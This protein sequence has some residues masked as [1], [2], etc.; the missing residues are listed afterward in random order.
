MIWLVLR[1]VLL[2]LMLLGL[3]AL[4]GLLLDS[5]GRVTLSIMGRE[6]P[7]L[8]LVE[9]LLAIA[10]MS[11]ALYLLYRLA[12][13]A[14]AV[15]RFIL[16]DETAL[17]RHWA[18]ARE[19]RG[20]DALSRGMIALAEGDARAADNHARKATRL[21]GKRELTQLLS[22][23]V[24]EAL[25]DDKRA[26]ESYRALA[27]SPETAMVGVKGLMTQAVRQGEIER[28]M[29]LA[30]HAFTLRP[31][32]PGVQQTLFDLQTRSGAWEGAKATLS[33]MEKT[34][35][36][37]ADVAARR[38]AVL[39]L[40]I[41]RVSWAE[42]DR[43]LALRHADAAVKAAQD[44]A[45]AAAFAAELHAAAGDAG[46][47]A[48]LLKSA[49]R[50]NPQPELAQAFAALEPGETPAERRR[51]FREL[52]SGKPDDPESKLLAAE[53]AIADHDA[54]AARKAL[55]DLADSD[56][57]HR[58]LAIM[59][60]VEKAEGA[61]ETVVRGYLARAVTA[62][63]GAHWRCERCAAAPGGWSAVC[64]ACGGFD[65]LAWRSDAGA[66]AGDAATMTPLLV[67]IGGGEGSNEA[68][69][70]DE[71]AAE[72]AGRQAAEARA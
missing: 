1:V 26:R 36:L 62:P 44:F 34:R 58:S 2:L 50:A 39:D 46:R 5:D 32:D 51:R 49:W 21:L 12:A 60:A 69:A 6:Y 25:G 23:Q 61:A 15:L 4:G 18:R 8:T 67:G 53:L 31:Q 47:A 68:D 7:S 55:G 57:T 30:A 40:E 20:L 54:H 59:A 22:A 29:K 48:R 19:R 45:P 13:L 64:P 38:R 9:A 10:A 27:K 66:P 42:G 56:P 35:A 65:T 28:A 11:A 41:A 63:R 52:L 70:L 3:A 43:A 71:A 37:P 17:S 24:A 72:S 33:A 16:G 14:V